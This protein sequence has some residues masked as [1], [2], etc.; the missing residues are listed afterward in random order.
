VDLINTD[1]LAGLQKFLR[2]SLWPS[3][4]PLYSTLT[5]GRSEESS[6]PPAFDTNYTD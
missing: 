2:T 4:F 3:R 6:I 1:N 5:A